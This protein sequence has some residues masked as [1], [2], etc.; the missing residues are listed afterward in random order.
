MRLVNMVK[1]LFSRKVNKYL[2]A[3]KV[4]DGLDNH[5]HL[6]T[7]YHES[8]EDFLKNSVSGLEFIDFVKHTEK[9]FDK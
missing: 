5:I 8:K 1:N 3:Y 6:S 4:I 7:S 9:Q 2:V